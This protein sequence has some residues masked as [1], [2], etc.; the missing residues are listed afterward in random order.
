M[1]NR[2]TQ[3]Q[4]TFCLKYIEL[5]NIGEAALMAGYSPK[6]APYIGSENLNKP[7]I[8]KRID[9]LR[10]KAED[11]TI[12]TVIER[13][14]VLTEIMRGR[15]V[16]FISHL[17]AEKLKSAALQEIR[18]TEVGKDIPIKTTT[19]KLHSP[20]QAIAELNKMEHIYEA[21]ITIDNRTLNIKV[22]DDPKRTLI[23]L[24]DRIA[25]KAGED[26]VGRQPD[27]GAAEET[28]V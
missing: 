8:I 15:F 12:A 24:L 19:I 20:I 11:A 28:T 23:S 2:L 26:K 10:Q 18:I 21:S 5:G 1:A 7:E 3:K 9:Q 6:T 17:T 14:Q 27:D 25:T 16:D 22:D 4:E 13:K